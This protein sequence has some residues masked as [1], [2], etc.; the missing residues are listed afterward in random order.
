[1][2]ERD[3]RAKDRLL[4]LLVH[5]LRS[6][7]TAVRNG[8]SILR[9]QEGAD[10]I[11]AQALDQLDRQSQ[12]LTRLLEELLDL[13]QLLDGKLRVRKEGVD[14]AEA[15]RQVEAAVR[16]AFAAQQVR[17]EMAL[18]PGPFAL[19]ADPARLQQMVRA[20]LLRALKYTQ[21]GGCV[22]LEAAREPAGAV[23]RVRDNGFGIAVD[24][25]THFFDLSAGE[26]H[27][28]GSAGVGML[29]A[30]GLAELH[31]GVVEVS[32]A[33]P[34]QGTELVVR[35]PSL[36]AL[37]PVAG[38]AS[39]A[40]ARETARPRRVLCVDDDADIAESLAHLLRDMGHDVQV[41]HSGPEAL[42]AASGY[43]PDVVLLDLGLPGMDGYELAR[44]LRRQ[45]GLGGAR[46]VAVS[47]YGQE[48]DRRRSREAGMDDHLLKPVKAAD[49][50]R[51]LA[52][53][54]GESA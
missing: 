16:P 32:S 15:V 24:V 54:T 31:G 13:S 35:L 46:L 11:T 42:A 53:A 38:P 3:T 22:R 28:P 17:L 18:P 26:G 14:L 8:V 34:G 51:A 33:G 39:A 21:P 25:V 41:A 2:C 37:H 7:L 50:A 48:E 23:V 1:V 52:A 12:Q 49:L 20:L 19:E 43:R 36:P 45:P 6:P 9:L 47:G 29:L 30:R 4:A 27:R 40:P 5:E 44:R 10:P